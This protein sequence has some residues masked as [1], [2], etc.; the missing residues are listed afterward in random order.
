MTRLAFGLGLAL[1][2][3]SCLMLAGAVTE[4]GIRADAAA[5]VE[6]AA[7]AEVAPPSAAS[8][9][10]SA[11]CFDYSLSPSSAPPAAA[12]S[13]LRSV[14]G[15]SLI[16][17]QPGLD[18]GVLFQSEHDR[19]DWSGSVK[20]F[21][22][23]LDAAGQVDAGALLWDGGALLTSMPA[24]LRQI[25]TLRA[26]PG[27][28]VRTIPFTW[29]MLSKKQRSA[30]DLAPWS[31]LDD[32]LGERRLDFLRGGRRLEIG[33]PGGIFRRRASVMG[34]AIHGAP[35]LVGAPSVGIAGTQYGA[36]FERHAKRPATLYL[37]ASDGM[38]HA[39]DAG[40]GRELFAYVPNLVLPLLN[41]LTS[42]DYRHQA[43]VDGDINA[44]EAMLDGQWK[45]VLVAGLGG[46]APG[47]FALDVSAP[48]RFDQGSGALWEFG[49]ADDGDIGHVVA[50]PLIAKL[51]VSTQRGSTSHRY[52]ALL[53]SGAD[54]PKGALF[55]LALDKP[56][57]ARWRVGVNYYKLALPAAALGPPALALGS[58]AAVR[59]VY[60]G[61]VQGNL[62]RFD[63]F[64][65]APANAAARLVF[66]ARDA[67]G[68]R[69]PITQ[70]PSVA[71]AP[72]GG[73]LVL[74]GTGKLSEPSDS[75]AARFAPQSFY[76][77]HDQPNQPNQSNQSNQS[78]QALTGRSA[79]VDV[80]PLATAPSGAKGW[81]LDFP[82]AASGE[83][84]IGRSSL[85]GGKVFFNTVLPGSASCTVSATRSYALDALTGLAGGVARSR[86]MMVSINPVPQR[87][88]PVLLELASEAGLRE[89]TGRML[90][91][92]RHLVLDADADATTQTSDAMP[93][94]RLNWR[95]IA[96]WPELHQAANKN[97]NGKTAEQTE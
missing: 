96:N 57:S 91:R 9:T 45:T 77:I 76:A 12:D 56:A 75:D 64:G 10:A 3:G 53:S 65:K 47:L 61:D 59:H 68:V 88:A 97:G 85:A 92:Q 13:V 6:V 95:E 52:F 25:Y 63:F 82:Q 29:S 4:P 60:A 93:A 40:N 94:Q 14:P 69:Q 30:L 58:D 81:Y 87:A 49:S 80:D 79:L 31:P 15:H 20:K 43:Y 17:F 70:A 50:A 18:T 7:D 23:T 62:W 89:A 72:G 8:A 90:V 28:P 35:L 22:V 2:L 42:P 19:L 11:Q 39:F 44:A 55:L 24:S 16:S 38:L 51:G 36:F 86:S 26:D 48:D 34:D 84:S 37:G 1:A 21:A 27:Q 33:Q 41:R 73:Y 78:N 83:R 54:Q 32:G 71:F 46:G 5:Y 74:F 67:A 66:V